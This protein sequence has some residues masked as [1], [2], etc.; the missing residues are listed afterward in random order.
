MDYFTAVEHDIA[1]EVSNRKQD[2]ASVR[3]QMAHDFAFNAAARAKLNRDMLHKMAVNARIARRDLDRFMRRTQ[4]HMARVA[5]L[6]NRRNKMN[7]RRDKR[8]L[9]IMK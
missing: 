4:M 1:Q 9:R 3:A 6:Q 8:T 2:I 7:L 5:Y